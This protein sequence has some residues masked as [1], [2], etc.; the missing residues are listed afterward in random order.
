MQKAADYI[1]LDLGERLGKQ[2]LWIEET[3]E[4]DEMTQGEGAEAKGE[5]KRL[6]NTHI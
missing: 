6:R 1:D 4:L 5:A 3:T 2:C